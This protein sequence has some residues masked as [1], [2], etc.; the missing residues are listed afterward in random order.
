MSLGAC[1]VSPVGGREINFQDVEFYEYFNYNDVKVKGEELYR[2][3][4]APEVMD[5]YYIL[6]SGIRQAELDLVID[7]EP[8]ANKAAAIE[9][10]KLVNS[11]DAINASILAH[12]EWKQPV[13][14]ELYVDDLASR[15]E[16]YEQF[17]KIEA[18]REANDHLYF[19]EQELAHVYAQNLK[20]DYFESVS[21]YRFATALAAA[22][23]VVDGS[24][25]YASLNSRIYDV[26]Y[27]LMTAYK[28]LLLKRDSLIE[29][30]GTADLLANIEIA[31]GIFAM[32]YDELVLSDIALEKINMVG[33]HHRLNGHE[34]E[35]GPGGGEGQGS[36]VCCSPS[37]PKESDTTERLN[38]NKRCQ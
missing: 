13:N 29:A 36:L 8:N 28:Q 21:W 14:K 22:E 5:T 3:Y 1:S 6:N 19:L 15:I 34:F 38:N 17:V 33:W 16:Y 30:G 32:D 24:D 18:N 26:K 7:A 10:T 11:E 37:G 31:E 12:E 9:A 4:L 25:P 20:E 23:A 35:Q 2:T 27:N